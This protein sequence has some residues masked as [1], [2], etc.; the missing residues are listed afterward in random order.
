MAFPA[1]RLFLQSARRLRGCDLCL[2]DSCPTAR[3][4]MAWALTPAAREKPN[5][6]ASRHASDGDAG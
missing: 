2:L 5:R 4:R 1:H 6:W 3:E